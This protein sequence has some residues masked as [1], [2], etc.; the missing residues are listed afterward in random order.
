G[1]VPGEGQTRAATGSPPSLSAVPGGKNTDRSA[2]RLATVPLTRACTTPSGVSTRARSP[3]ARPAS[4][5]VRSSTVTSPG[6]RGP[7]PVTGAAGSAS[8]RAQE[9][10]QER[11]AMP[12]SGRPSASTYAGKGASVSTRSTPGRAA[13]SAT[14][15]GGSRTGSP[16][17][18]AASA[19][20]SAGTRPVTTTGAASNRQDA[21]PPAADRR[22]AESC[23]ANAAVVNPPPSATASKDS[24]RTRIRAATLRTASVITAAPTAGAAP[25]RRR[26]RGR[27]ARRRAA[28][29]AG[30]APG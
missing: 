4:A 25:G 21:V 10:P 7:R 20:P 30:T 17:G 11:S 5:A 8:A 28:R 26:G 2:V 3:T 19:A 1:S 27:R 24:S 13:I 29:H 23:N 12:P 15:A 16:E 18:E 9:W 14:V 6:R 22:S